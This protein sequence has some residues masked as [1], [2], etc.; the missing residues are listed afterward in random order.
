MVQVEG[1]KTWSD[2]FPS[3]L[4][5]GHENQITESEMT[6]DDQKSTEIHFF[7]IFGILTVGDFSSKVIKKRQQY[8]VFVIFYV[9]LDPT[10]LH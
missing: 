3:G 6:S 5:V 10:G 9:F 2:R 4:T 8:Y 1:P 7:Q